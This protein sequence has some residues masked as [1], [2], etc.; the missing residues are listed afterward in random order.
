MEGISHLSDDELLAHDSLMADSSDRD[1]EED[2]D[3]EDRR[4]GRRLIRSP[5]VVSPAGSGLSNGGNLSFSRRTVVNATHRHTIGINNFTRRRGTP[6]GSSSTSTA[7]ANN[8]SAVGRRQT[9]PA[10]R[11]Q[12]QARRSLYPNIANELLTDDD[13][14]QQNSI[15]TEDEED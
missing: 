3:E 1:E 7:N 2:L 15:E 4:F 8:T 6:T 9:M 5:S 13:E 11:S 10:S 12:Q 14:E